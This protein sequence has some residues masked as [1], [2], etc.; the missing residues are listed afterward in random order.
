MIIA[1]SAAN[2]LPRD[3]ISRYNV[4]AVYGLRM[5]LYSG[6]THAYVYQ[7]L[8]HA[9]RN[10]KL[11]FYIRLSLS[12]SLCQCAPCTI[13]KDLFKSVPRCYY[14]QIVYLYVWLKL[15][16]PQG[17]EET[18]YHFWIPPSMK[19][20]TRLHTANAQRTLHIYEPWPRPWIINKSKATQLKTSAQFET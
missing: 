5:C 1:P 13:W 9:N 7:V 20:H 14:I 15:L 4:L 18:S 17:Y 2:T 10:Y 11:P 3:E 16:K 19:E 6:W 8:L 12:P